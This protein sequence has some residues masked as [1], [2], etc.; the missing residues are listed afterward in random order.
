MEDNLDMPLSKV[1]SIMQNRILTQS[2][3]FGIKALMS[4]LDYWVY[5]EILFAAKPDVIVEIGNFKGGSTL[6]LAHMCDLLGSGRVIGIDLCHKAV[7]DLVKQ[8]PR[9][10]LLEG[11][12]CQRFEEVRGLISKEERVLVIEDSS[13]TYEN[14]L[15]V[16]HT[17]SGLLKPGDYFIVEDG[18]CQHGLPEGT[19]PGPYEAVEQF[20]TENTDFEIDRGKESFLITWNPKGYLKRIGYTVPESAKNSFKQPPPQTKSSTRDILKL[21]LPPIL[22]MFIRKLRKGS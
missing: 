20:V 4:P 19:S 22:V 18:I 9:I 7:P 12:A 3:Y 11:D 1:L 21:L 14:T 15:R 13:H 8:H 10:T 17:F 5:Q 2:T 6:S 16:L